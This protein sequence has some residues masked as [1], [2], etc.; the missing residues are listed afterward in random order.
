MNA[1]H[2]TKK[3]MMHKI[4]FIVGAIVIMLSAILYVSVIAQA[5]AEESVEND[6]S[7]IL[8]GGKNGFVKGDVLCN[9]IKVD[10]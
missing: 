10:T 7:L 3:E 1:K 8:S 4:V 5:N 6:S 2:L 9:E